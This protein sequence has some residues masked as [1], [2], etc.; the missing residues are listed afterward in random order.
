[1]A[2]DMKKHFLHKDILISNEG[3]IYESF[4]TLWDGTYYASKITIL[5]EESMEVVGKGSKAFDPQLL[6]K[7]FVIMDI[8]DS[9]LTFNK[10][11]NKLRFY[12]E[13]IKKSL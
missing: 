1:M 13:K 10:I 8:L 6:N 7:T 5:R 3:Y 9:E 12:V 11:E 2:C 4:I